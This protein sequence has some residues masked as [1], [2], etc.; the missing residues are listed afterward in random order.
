M[1]SSGLYVFCLPSKWTKGRFLII[2]KQVKGMVSVFVGVFSPKRFFKA[3]LLPFVGIQRKAGAIGTTAR[4]V[5][6]PV[7]AYHVLSVILF[8][9][10]PWA[11]IRVPVISVG[12][13]SYRTKHEWSFEGLKYSFHTCVCACTCWE[14]LEDQVYQWRTHMLFWL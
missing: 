5:V 6:S 4:W 3:F 8:G 2:R 13:A 7:V 1:T 12:V 14:R 9:A 11:L 10:Y